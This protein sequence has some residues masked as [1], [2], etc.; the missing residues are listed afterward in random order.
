LKRELKV[1]EIVKRETFETS[2]R[3]GDIQLFYGEVEVSYSW[4]FIL[5]IWCPIS[6]KM[7]H[8]SFRMGQRGFWSLGEKG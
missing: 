3:S 4:Y 1:L 2:I 5:V 8:L 6:Y 7:M